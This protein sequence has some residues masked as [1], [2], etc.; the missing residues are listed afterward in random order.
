MPK[1]RSYFNAYRRV[2]KYAENSFSPDGP[3]T[4]IVG[5]GTVELTVRTSPVKGSANRTLVL[6][7]VLHI[8]GAICRCAWTDPRITQLRIIGQLMNGT[9]LFGM[10]SASVDYAD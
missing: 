5:I 10:L 4:Y 2:G 6:N 1:S 9:T 7:N 8:P 3:K